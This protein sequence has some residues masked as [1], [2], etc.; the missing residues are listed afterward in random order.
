MRLL[1]LLPGQTTGPAIPG[2]PWWTN[3]GY[4]VP[5]FELA[6]GSM[7]PCWRRRDG[8][9]YY[10]TRGGVYLGGKRLPFWETVLNTAIPNIDREWPIPRPAYR[11]GQVWLTVQGQ[12]VLV[13]GVYADGAPVLGVAVPVADL[14]HLVHDPIIPEDAPW[15]AVESP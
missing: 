10:P 6:A 14:V 2:R 1:P 3:V 5:P 15:S 9:T 13:L 11:A 8:L 4:V 12:Q 7:L